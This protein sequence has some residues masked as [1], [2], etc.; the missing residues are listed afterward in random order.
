MKYDFTKVALNHFDGV[1]LVLCSVLFR[2]HALSMAA[3]HHV[4]AGVSMARHPARA[5][6]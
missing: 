2:V 4:R 1:A 3:R 5:S 6:R